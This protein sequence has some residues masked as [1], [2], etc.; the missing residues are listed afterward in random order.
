[1]LGEGGL[2]VLPEEIRVQPGG[3]VAPGQH[4]VARAEPGHE[5]VRIETFGV[6]R[7]EPAVERGVMRSYLDFEKPVAELEAKV[8]E[9]RASLWAPAEKLR[10]ASEEAA[11]AP[12][13]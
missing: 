1:M 2:P 11:S 13:T 5:P 4:F 7:V 8:E 9:L 12:P 6:H 3:D 10:V